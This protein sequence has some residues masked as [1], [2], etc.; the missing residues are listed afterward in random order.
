[1]K[2]VTCFYDENKAI[3]TLEGI[4]IYTK[5]ESDALLKELEKKNWFYIDEED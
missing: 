5:N 1:M 4:T 2:D 3:V